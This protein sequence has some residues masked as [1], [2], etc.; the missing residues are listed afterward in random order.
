MSTR[1]RP[2]E[3]KPAGS[4]EVDMEMVGRLPDTAPTLAAGE[5]AK[6]AIGQYYRN[7]ATYHV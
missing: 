5:L 3:E 4:E 1:R 7:G 6:I 2:T